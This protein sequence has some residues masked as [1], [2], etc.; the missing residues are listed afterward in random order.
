MT[1]NKFSNSDQLSCSELVL[2]T[3]AEGTPTAATNGYCLIIY[4][5]TCL[6]DFEL[7]DD[8]G[9]NIPKPPDLLQLYRNCGTPLPS[10]REMVD[11]S[12]GV[13]FCDL[14]G[15]C[16]A[17]D[18]AKKPDLSQ[19]VCVPVCINLYG[20]N[21]LMYADLAFFLLSLFFKIYLHDLKLYTGNEK[22]ENNAYTH[23]LRFRSVA[24]THQSRVVEVGVFK[25]PWK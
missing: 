19:Q 1:I 2:L 16:N 11:V 24:L 7:W 14:P 3:Y 18:P 25:R 12:V 10:P 6:Q 4:I 9:L 17:Q 13:D 8:V 20:C 23:S 5:F 22:A 15:N 21:S